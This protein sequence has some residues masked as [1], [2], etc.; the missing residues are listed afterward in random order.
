VP[1]RSSPATRRAAAGGRS[2]GTEGAPP[3]DARG[4]R[5]RGRRGARTQRRLLDAAVQVFDERGYHAARVDDIVKAAK[6]SHGTFYLYF[7][8]KEELFT[9]LATEVA[10]QMRTLA[11]ALPPVPATP[12]GVDVLRAWLTQ[13]GA[14]YDRY[15][16]V[17]RAWTEAEIAGDGVGRIGEELLAGFSAALGERVA[18]ATAGD[19]APNAAIAGT[20]LLAMIERLSYYRVSNQMRLDQG[21]VV[22]A[23]ARVT[24]AAMF[25]ATP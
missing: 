1:P 13:F 3:G 7:A 20:A 5:A 8:N 11:G 25:G 4:E 16:P 2:G 6:T 10:E 22:D 17:V 23:L 14:L 12:D 21:E 18:E 19:D 15:S 9:E 24:H